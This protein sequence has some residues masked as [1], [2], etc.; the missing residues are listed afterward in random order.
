MT[1]TIRTHNSIHE[2]VAYCDRSRDKRYG[3]ASSADNG[4]WAGTSS[5]DEA[6]SL[7]V[8]GWQDIRPSIDAAIAPIRERLADTLDTQIIRVFDMFGYEPDVDRFVAGEMDCMIDDFMHEEPKTGKVFTV[9]ISGTVNAFVTADT[10]LKRG[11]AI[12]GLIEAFQ[13][14]GYDLEL[15]YEDSVKR[16]VADQYSQLVRIHRAGD[17]IDLNTLMFPLAHPSWLRRFFFAACEGESAAMRKAFGFKK[18]HG[19]GSAADLLCVEQVNPSFVLTKGG[20]T[21][22]T[23]LMDSDPVAWILSVLEA[24]GV[25]EPAS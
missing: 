23:R 3:T 25:Y 9:L 6:M 14:L 8:N 24:Q 21:P 2:Y 7:A 17:L 15:W 1:H 10:L 5:W 4:D 22:D 11:T 18:G 13:I 20:S 16:G 19:Y 12:A